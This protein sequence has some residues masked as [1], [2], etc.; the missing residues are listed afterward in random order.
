[1]IKVDFGL[2][3]FRSNSFSLFRKCHFKRNILPYVPSSVLSF[4]L[5]IWL[6]VETNLNLLDNNEIS[7]LVSFR[8]DKL[9]TFLLTNLPLI[10]P[11]KVN[12]SLPSFKWLSE[13]SQPVT[14]CIF[15]TSSHENQ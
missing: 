11:F 10:H 1:M 7:V 2:N 4:P 8:S 9:T 3:L 5:L 14:L 12:A 6:L 15:K 13:W